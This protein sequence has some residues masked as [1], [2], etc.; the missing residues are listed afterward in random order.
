MGSFTLY[1]QF[2]FEFFT[3]QLLARSRLSDLRRSLLLLHH[4]VPSLS[5]VGLA[6]YTPSL[7]IGLLVH[8]RR[9]S[10]RRAL[11]V[12]GLRGWRVGCELREMNFSLLSLSLSFSHSFLF[13]ACLL[14]RSDAFCVAFQRSPSLLLSRNPFLPIIASP[15]TID[16]VDYDFIDFFVQLAVLYVSYHTVRGG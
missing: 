6:A 3:F 15:P 11:V 14:V 5:N 10:N 8:F 1:I 12:H 7:T 2:K 9:Q 4:L 16:A 13:F